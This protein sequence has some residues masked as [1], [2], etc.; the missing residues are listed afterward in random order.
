[1]LA[2]IAL[3]CG[4]AIARAADSP[5]GRRHLEPDDYYRTQNITEPQCSPDGAWVAYVVTVNDRDADEARSAVWLVSWDG[6]QHVRLTNPSASVRAPRWSPDGR[7]LSFLGTPAGTDSKQIM[8]LDRRGGEARQLTTVG[9]EIMDYAWSPD[10][11][12]LLVVVRH[13]TE[14]AAGAAKESA[15]AAKVPKPIVI[16][17]MH[18]KVDEDG[19]IAAGSAQHLYLVDVETG[20]LGALTQDV[21]VTD[22][23]PA[24]SPDGTQ[25]AFVR[26]HER[27][28][29]PDGMTDLDVIDSRIGATA[30][31]I[32]RVYAPN[33][34]HLAWSPDST[35]V[36]FL[37]GLEPKYSAY[38][39]DQLVVIPARGGGL[40][41]STNRLD[42]AIE[43][44]EFTGDGKAV[45]AIVEDDGLR[46]PARIDLAT[47]ASERLL[48]GADV[49]TAMSAG[50][51]HTAVI[52]SSDAAAP[53]IYALEQ[54]RL[55]K[56]TG[57]NDALFA[58]LELGAVEDIR[59]RSRD[60][61]EIHGFIV[62]PPGYIPARKYPTIVWIHGG[63]NLQDQ[64]G[65][66][67]DAYTRQM[68]RQLLAAQGYVVLA[69]NYRGSS[70]RGAAF[71]RAIFGDWG[72]REIEDLFA[73]IDYVVA[74]GIAD[75]A[76]LGIGGWSYGGILTD[77]AITS[78]R[79]FK[80]AVSGAGS[81]NQLAMYGSDEYELQYNNEL[82]P[83]W[84]AS[85]RWMKVSYP[86]FHADRIHTPTLFLGGDKDFNVPV[87]GGEQMYQAL[88][89]LGVPTQ[90]VV[91]PG[92]YHTLTRPSF[93]HDR[94]ERILDW[95]RRYLAPSR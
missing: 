88:R 65:L 52:A 21:G 27:E 81:G 42:R 56:L 68:Q 66:P 94:A 85:A 39:Q 3:S 60:G 80:A 20:K 8:L 43:E 40:R 93:L 73:G 2:G 6:S 77:Y 32:I 13:S 41:A 92:Q 4:A 64:H 28:A 45:A 51:G 55:R 24:W 22:D 37:Q 76:H 34:Q 62:K 9:E 35:L 84:R 61:T 49:V 90:L 10:G 70:G 17:A 44:P 59:F 72:H 71:S 82:G 29:D 11:K 67:V 38:I 47:G 95:F 30:R 87:A 53:E 26:S 75:G 63:P 18:F 86:F 46:Y 14:P 15:E 31:Q 58:E 1:V 5:A 25:I 33:H 23:S 12:R 57:H 36:A 69:I 48:A 50:A 79:R 19:Y 91:Y 16:D 74:R 78:D 7:Y 89:T 83:P 54:G